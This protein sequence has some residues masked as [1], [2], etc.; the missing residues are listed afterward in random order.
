[1]DFRAGRVIAGTTR[2]N[3]SEDFIRGI[4]DV[5][6]AAAPRPAGA[7]DPRQLD[8]AHVQADVG[9]APA[10]P[11]SVLPLHTDLVFVAEPG[12]ILLLHP[13]PPRSPR[14]RLPLD[15]RIAALQAYVSL[16]NREYA[17]PYPRHGRSAEDINVL[18][19]RLLVVF[20]AARVEA[21]CQS[22]T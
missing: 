11:V 15:E 2:R 5:L 14:R 12:D 9:V 21:T 17:K 6:Q 16:H 8:G 3:R 7:R 19:D 1:M 10:P 4:G 13:H 20:H 18:H 22:V